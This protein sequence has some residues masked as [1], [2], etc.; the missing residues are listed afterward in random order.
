MVRQG[1]FRLS[2]GPGLVLALGATAFSS[3]PPRHRPLILASYPT[4]C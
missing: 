2:L 1:Y 4:I 3:P